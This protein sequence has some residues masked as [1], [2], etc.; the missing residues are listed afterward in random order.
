MQENPKTQPQNQD[1]NRI[2]SIVED[3]FAL[4]MLE[5]A[6]AQK[7][8]GELD[9]DETDLDTEALKRLETAVSESDAAHSRE[10]ALNHIRGMSEAEQAQELARQIA[11]DEALQKAMAEEIALAEK[12]DTELLA[13]LPNQEILDVAEIQSCVEALLFMA[14]RPISVEKL[15]ELLGPGFTPAVFQEAITEL[16]DRY[17]ATHHGIELVKIAGGF[18]FRTKPGRAALA[19][20][21]ARTQTQRLSSGALE[22]LAIVAYKQPA[23]KE[24]ID[25]IRGVDSS[26]FIRGLLDKKLIRISGRSELPGRPMEYSTTQEFLEVFGL[27][28][29]AA[30]PALRELENMIPASQIR[31]EEDPRVAE[32]RKLVGEM[33]ADTST[34]LHYDPKEDEKLLQ[35]IRE[36]VSSIP[37]STPSLEEQKAVDVQAAQPELS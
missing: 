36:R 30:L 26:Y 18:Q 1:D 5:I 28:D 7:D 35:E 24:D 9:L 29:L 31:G 34:T 23:M 12:G 15:R 32:M 19:R 25:K 8:S 3:P 4:N 17:K 11:E 21:L 10:T 13:A 27:A 6:D 22:T 33:N 2:V 37:T 20:R 16:C 14:D